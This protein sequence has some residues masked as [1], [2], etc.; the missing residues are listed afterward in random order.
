M[1]KKRASASLNVDMLQKI[2]KL[3]ASM[4]LD[5]KLGMVHG[6]N[7]YDTKG[8]ERLGIPPFRFSDGPM[9][10]RCEFDRESCNYVGDSDDYATS[11]PCTT[12]VAATWNP[13]M[14]Y[15]NGKAL[16]R[17]VRGRGK[18]VSLSPGINI[19][20]TPLCGRNFEYMS[21]D[22][23]LISKMCVPEIQ[24]LQENDIAACVKHFVANNQETR[25]GD[26]NVEIEERALQEIY[27]PG[28]KAAVQ[29]GHSQAI[30]GAY[31]RFR[32][33]Y[34]CQNK[35]LLQKLLRKEWGFDGVV[36]SDWGAV[37]DTKKAVDAGVHFEM[38]VDNRYD[39]Y[40]YANP[41]RKLIESGEI[42]EEALDNMVRQILKMMFR[43]KMIDSE[44]T[45][46]SYNS[47]ENRVSAWKVA[48]ESIVLLKNEKNILPLKKDPRRLIAVIGENAN[49]LHAFGGGSSEVKAL[50]EITPLLGLKMY[51][52]GNY[53]VRYAKGY[54]SDSQDAGKR[55]Q[56]LEEACT[57][58]ASADIVIYV[59]G[60]NHDFDMESKDRENMKLPFGQDKL[61]EN[62]LK[63]NPDTVIVNM[64]GSPVEMSNWI[65]RAD[66]V[67]QFWYSG[68]EGGTA[69][70]EVLFGD[71]N[72]SGKLPVT[73]PK[74]LEDT[75]VY[76]FGEFPGNDT[77]TY[78]E[79][80]YV[81]Y[82]YYDSYQVEPEFC[83]GHGVSYT[84]FAYT[85]LDI[86]VESESVVKVTFQLTNTGSMAGA[87]VAQLYISDPEC[88]V[89]R[90]A[91]E[92]KGF[93][94]VFLNPGETREVSIQLT[95]Q[96]FCYYSV[97]DADWKLESGDFEILVGSSSRDIRLHQT[98][99]L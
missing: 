96:D 29:E 88:S 95:G 59:G 75:P 65:D 52:G 94:K 17:E 12:A 56:L 37:H 62:L 10:V 83:F 78:R 8:V 13:E 54:S 22:P 67:V 18:D 77:V 87:E 24:G 76:R 43:L 82:R 81:G 49:R 28:F 85:D 36:V 61:I 79:G 46:G 63:A 53:Q 71:V 44:R 86:Q 16:G 15:E 19:Q 26:V 4:T 14:A 11:F 35:Y 3:L 90:P 68:S 50:Y 80:I 38:N 72:P 66:T 33:E 69:L 97:E 45:P 42:K 98:I 74:S 89:P 27:L 58:A 47:L 41:L 25:R 34:C 23:Y 92:L 51:L 57:L 84:D 60:L 20:R 7:V 55:E 9:G 32:G 6:D 39:E 2:E 5:E 64:S 31:N 99:T 93:E 48:R 40:Y 1:E 91:K 21:E 73:F 30:M 70:A